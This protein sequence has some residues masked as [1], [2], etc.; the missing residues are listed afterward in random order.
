VRSAGYKIPSVTVAIG[1]VLDLHVQI[2]SATR[3]RIDEWRGWLIVI[4]E[5]GFALRAG[6]AKLFLFSPKVRR[7]VAGGNLSAA[8]RAYRRW[9]KRDPLELVQH[10]VADTVPYEQ[11][12]VLR[13]GYRSDK[14]GPAGKEHDYDHDFL[15]H[16]GRP[17]KLYT[18]RSSIEKSS[19]A[20]LV[21]GSMSISERGIA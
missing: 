19:A 1:T 15:E 3:A 6:H 13:I 20:V 4:P 2:D 10:K 5:H 11:A 12:R 21:G 8:E 17:P 18:D 14:W 16:G 9:H 7:P